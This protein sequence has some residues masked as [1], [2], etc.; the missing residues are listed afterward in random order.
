MTD[1][2]VMTKSKTQL[3]KIKGKIF[4]RIVIKAFT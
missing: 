1:F 2:T 3:N 4:K